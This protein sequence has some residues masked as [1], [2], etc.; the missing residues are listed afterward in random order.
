[1]QGIKCTDFGIIVNDEA[2][3]A[4]WSTNKKPPQ[5]WRFTASQGTRVE[6]Q[7]LVEQQ[8]VQ[9]VPATLTER[10]QQHRDTVWAITE[11]GE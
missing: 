4:V 10:C 7:E 3:C 8:F 2:H 6:M 5:G 9:T 1:M 11:F